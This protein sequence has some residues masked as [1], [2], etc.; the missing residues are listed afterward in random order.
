MYSISKRIRKLANE[1]IEIFI[2]LYYT[3]FNNYPFINNASKIFLLQH[4][5]FDC[6]KFILAIKWILLNV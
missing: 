4:L 5:K 2:V 3:H 6:N 1:T